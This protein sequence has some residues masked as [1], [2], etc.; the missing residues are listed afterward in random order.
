MSLLG[1]SLSSAPKKRQR[2]DDELGRLTVI[3]C[4]W[5]KCRRYRWA[6]RRPVHCH[7]L[8][9]FSIVSSLT[10]PPPDVSPRILR[11]HWLH[12]HLM[13]L[14]GFCDLSDYIKW[15]LLGFCGFSDYIRWHLLAFCDLSDYITTWCISWDFMVSLTASPLDA[16]PGILWFHSLHHH[17]MHL[18]SF[19][20]FADCITTWCI[21]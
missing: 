3:C 11:S 10:T 18:L 4:T 5:K 12:H 16:S 14:L 7:L 2:N 13:H 21:S 6:G 1:S 20:D 15:H 19:C 9:F 17:L 8:G